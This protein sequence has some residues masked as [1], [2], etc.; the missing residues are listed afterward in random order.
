MWHPRGSCG[1]QKC[2]WHP[3]RLKYTWHS[4]VRS[5][6]LKNTRLVFKKKNNNMALKNAHVALKNAYV[7]LTNA[8]VALTK[9]HMRH[10]KIHVRQ[11]KIHKWHSK[12]HK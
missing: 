12:M 11:S 2:V 10:S 5:V 3:T 1:T 4:R 8:Y 7:A 9:L 6:A